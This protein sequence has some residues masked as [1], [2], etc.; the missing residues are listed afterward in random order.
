MRR[1]AEEVLKAIK[2]DRVLGLS[3]PELMNK[4]S[5]PK[6][7]IWHHIR[8]V[9]MP[10]PLWLA[11]KSR[12]GGSKIRSGRHWIQAQQEALVLLKNFKEHTAWPIVLAAL[13]WAEGT[14][15]KG[16]VF[17]NTDESMIRIFLSI[18]KRKL[19]V[20]NE[21]LDI[22]IRT[23]TPMDPVKCKKHWSSVTGLPKR[24][25]RINHND[26]QNKS[27]TRYG[28]CRITLRKGAYHL[29]LVHCLIRTL[30]DKMLGVRSRSSTDRTSHS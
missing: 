30:T 19:K 11:L 18:M 22:L 3:M 8:N 9:H 26:K 20:H 16:F 25:I 23:C 21:N 29:K 17:T 13:Y 10:E 14:K 15:K 1:H 4:Y 2:S 12:Q 6:T 28:M 24:M 27:K 7:T 5:L